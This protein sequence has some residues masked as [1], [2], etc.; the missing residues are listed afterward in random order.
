MLRDMA[1][2]IEP[3]IYHP[4]RLHE[5][6]LVLVSGVFVIDVPLNDCLARNRST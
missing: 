2:G 5:V 6:G 4:S 1:S 3:A